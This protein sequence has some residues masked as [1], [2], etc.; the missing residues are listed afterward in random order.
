M[1]DLKFAEPPPGSVEA[2]DIGCTCAV[3]DNRRG[4]GAQIISDDSPR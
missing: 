1:S 3:L 4:K 2:Q